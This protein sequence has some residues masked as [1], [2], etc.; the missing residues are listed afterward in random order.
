MPQ[1]LFLGPTYPARSNN[2]AA[3]RCVNFFPE[4]GPSDSQGQQSDAGVIALIGTPGS[5]LAFSVAASVIRGMHVFNNLLYFVAGDKLYSVDSNGLVSAALGTLATSTGRVTI[6]DNGIAASGAGGN[7]LYIVDGTGTGY[8]YDVL[9][10]TF[11]TTTGGVK[12]TYLDGYFITNVPGSMVAKASDAFDG[13]TFES[14]SYQ[15]VLGSSDNL[16]CV[17]NLNNQLWMIKEF[18]SQIW[19]NNGTSPNLGFPFSLIPGTTIDYGTPAPDSVVRGDQALFM[20]ANARQGD[21]GKFAGIVM[22]Q[23]NSPQIVSPPAIN[24]QISQYPDITDAF[25]FYRVHEG[26]SF[27]VVT[28]PSANDGL[29]ATFVYDRSTGLFHEWASYLDPFQIGRHKS[30]CYSY[31]AGKEYFGDSSTGN[32]YELSSNYFDEGGEPI[33]SM[34][35]SQHQADRRDKTNIFITRLHVDMETGVG[36]SNV[37]LQTGIDPQAMLSWSNDAGH[38]YGNDYLASIGKVGNYKLRLIWRRLGYARDRV[39]KLTISD[40]VKKVITGVFV[41]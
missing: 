10:T 34:R 5:K 26:H 22:I 30:N 19:A 33:V 31:F 17:T 41:N 35:I 20:V 27:Y 1:T 28:F 16:Q 13:T 18:N 21:I 7:Q 40:P 36:D 8:I 4:V 6:I 23:G 39:F 12:A 14:L 38:T 11:S 9:T 24:Y 32:I 29:G 25:G 3:D 15:A 2:I 37:L